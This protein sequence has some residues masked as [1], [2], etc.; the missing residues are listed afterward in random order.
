MIGYGG[1]HVFTAGL[2]MIERRLSEWDF[3][4]L[5]VIGEGTRDPNLSPFLQKYDSLDRRS[6]S[7][8]IGYP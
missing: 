3:H 6:R 4:V 5:T 8:S 1:E 2:V 7:A